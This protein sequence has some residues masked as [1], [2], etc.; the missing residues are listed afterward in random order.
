MQ[1]ETPAEECVLFCLQMMDYSVVANLIRSAK[2][3][4]MDVLDKQRDGSQGWLGMTLNKLKLLQFMPSTIIPS[5]NDNSEA[6]FQTLQDHVLPDFA[7]P[8]AV[9]KAYHVSPEEQT[10]EHRVEH[11]GVAGPSLSP[12]ATQFRD[13][14]LHIQRGL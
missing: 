13:F 9:L 11:P 7:N 2:F 6:L 12:A 4:T 10:N 5:M 14:P 3:F 8:A 1:G